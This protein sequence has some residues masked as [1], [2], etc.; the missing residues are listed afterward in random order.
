MHIYFKKSPVHAQVYVKFYN[1]MTHIAD[2]QLICHVS[3]A[4]GH[5]TNLF[6]HKNCFVHQH[7][8]CLVKN[9]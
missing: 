4:S 7:G 8:H 3:H 6:L 2:F 9:Q 1:M 5:K